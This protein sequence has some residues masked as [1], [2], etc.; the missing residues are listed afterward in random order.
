MNV[1]K[2]NLYE[3]NFNISSKTSSVDVLQGRKENTSESMYRYP[4]L[5]R[6]KAIWGKG[7]TIGPGIREDIYFLSAGSVVEILPMSILSH[8]DV[9]I[10]RGVFFCCNL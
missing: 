2:A 4:S 8:F 1:I 6:W 3:T 10:T 9:G 7:C 5:A